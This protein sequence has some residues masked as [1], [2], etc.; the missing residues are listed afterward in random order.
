MPA[1][2][3]ADGPDPTS[4]PLARGDE[5]KLL[6]ALLRHG[7]PALTA[8]GSIRDRHFTLPEHWRLFRAIVASL[9]G[10]LPQALGNPA[11]IAELAAEA[12]ELAAVPARATAVID[13]WIRRE[14]VHIAFSLAT[15][16]TANTGLTGAESLALAQRRLAEL[17][18][19]PCIDGE[20]S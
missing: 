10:D 20:P 13:A 17:H 5:R 7:R 4:L 18:P 1:F 12:P 14:L 16:A 2:K 9:D 8:A 3:P 15:N 6:G 19:R 11:F